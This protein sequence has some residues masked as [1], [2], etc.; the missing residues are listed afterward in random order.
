MAFCDVTNQS[1]DGN[2]HGATPAKKIGC[3][4]GGT[5]RYHN[6]YNA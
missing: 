5:K 3:G 6:A 4:G 1:N 2:V